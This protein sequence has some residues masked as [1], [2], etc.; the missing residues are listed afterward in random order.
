MAAE[1]RTEMP[2]PAGFF[3]RLAAMV[4]DSLLVAALLISTIT[5][6]VVLT[7]TPVA[8]ANV[9]GLLLLESFA[10]FAYF[11]IFRGQTLGMLAWRL[12]IVTGSGYRMTFSQAMLRYFGALLSFASL[13]LGYLWILFDAQKRG[14]PDLI[15]DSRVLY[16]PKYRST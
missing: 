13:G 6:M 14:W 3:R 7:N 12:S 16:T 1:E 9:L 10:F 8:Q 2:L 5:L 15:S 4:Y 11:W